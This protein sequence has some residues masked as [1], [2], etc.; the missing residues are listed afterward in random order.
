MVSLLSGF[1]SDLFVSVWV[2]VCLNAHARW[3]LR[4]PEEGIGSPAGGAISS[5]VLLG[6]GAGSRARVLGKSNESLT[7]EPFLQA[8]G[9]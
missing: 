1:P 9:S 3:C 5:C 4:N 6:M 2:Y 8:C 7:T